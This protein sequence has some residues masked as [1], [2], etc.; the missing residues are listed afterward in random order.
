MSEAI[1]VSNGLSPGLMLIIRLCLTAGR[2]SYTSV[3]SVFQSGLNSRQRTLKSSVPNFL[4]SYILLADIIFFKVKCRDCYLACKRPYTTI[5]VIQ[6][7]RKSH[8]FSAHARIILFTHQL[9]LLL[10]LLIRAMK[11]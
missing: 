6:T 3:T 7:G 2:V 5:T 10:C 11:E 1:N 4:Q 8:K 9:I